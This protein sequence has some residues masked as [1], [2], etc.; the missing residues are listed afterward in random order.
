MFELLFKYPASVFEK[1]HFVFLT[2]WPLWLLALGV[3]AAAGLLFWH[4]RRNHGMLTG[5]RPVAIWL[6]ETALVALLLLLLWHPAM[7]VATLKPQQNVVA[8]LVD[9]SRS[10]GIADVSGTREDAARTLL[11]GGLLKS[12]S[13]RFQVRLYAFGK[14]PVRIQSPGQLKATE[15]ASRLGDTLVRVLAESSSLPLG[16]V[17]MLSDGSD[18]SGGVDLE[19]ISAIRR[20]RI[21]IHTIGFGRER[22]DRDVEIV[23]A[24]VLARALPQSKLTVQVT[25]QSYGLSGQKTRLSVRDGA[26]TLISR[27]I[28]LQADGALQ[29]ES[30]VFDCGP[31]GPKTL[32]IAVDPVS[33]EENTL[34]NKVTRLVNVENRKPR[35]LYVEGEPR[36]DYKFIRRALDD[37]PNIEIASMLRTTQ[38]KIYRQGT[39]DEKE[40]ADGFPSKADELFAYQGLIIGSVEAGYFTAGQQALIR[41]FVDRRGGGLLF[42]GGRASLSDGG[43]RTSPLADLVPTRLPEGTGTFHRD[44]TGQQLTA[45]GA[46]SIICRLDDDDARNAEHW[47]KMPQMAS[48][49]DVGEAKPGATVLLESTPAGHRPLPLLV[50]ENYGRGRT[51][52]FATGGSWRWKMWTDHADKS[53]PAF[54]Q[55]IFRYLVTDAPGQVAAST[56]KAVLAD[57][58]RVPVR[59]EVRDKEFKPVN[60]AKVQARFMG[61]EG[62]NATMELIPQPLEEGV[63]TGEWSAEKPGSYVVEILAGREQEAVGNDVLTFRREDGVA[64]NFHTSQ[65]RELLEKLAQQTGGRYYKPADASKL[66]TEISYSEAGITTRETRDLW[67]L[68]LVF[69]LALAIK[70][71]EWLLRRKWGVV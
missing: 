57:E 38:N 11:E 13:D 22:P 55:Q 67:D 52:V 31:A 46:Q 69:L 56:P 2:P 15:P 36:W 63:Y 47:K 58:T 10:M 37:Y 59:V 53:H 42:L 64:E 8:I 17:V 18:N 49:Q 14:E 54:W 33:G 23:D 44:F 45:A 5:A 29:S 6:L 30:M 32:E 68:P 19:T 27:E 9:N 66:S 70:S 71:S 35:I 50:T 21:P 3:A 39:R 12:L 40:L 60:N 4:V 16:A 7:S 1:G 41:D 61:P 43:Y 62:V 20:Q 48:Y 34:N 65:N 24:V 26:R 25:L 51:M 28:A